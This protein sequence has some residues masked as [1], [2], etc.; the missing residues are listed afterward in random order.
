[1]I[2]A[3][4]VYFSFS[5]LA[6]RESN[7]PA[8]EAVSL[9]SFFLKMPKAR[10]ELRLQ[11]IGLIMMVGV[12]TIATELAKVQLI[13]G[14][15]WAAKIHTGGQVKV[16][17]PG[18]RGYIRDRNGVILAD[19]RPSY[20]IDFYFPDIVQGYED[21]L[22]DARKAGEEVEDFGEDI[23]KIVNESGHSSTQ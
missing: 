22:R 1:M 8:E 4:L 5:Y 11:L 20:D 19:N 15:D 17:S 14:E 16:R 10:T 23:V 9:N 6:E 12:G 18:I 21:K 7:L 3:P 2:A 13:E